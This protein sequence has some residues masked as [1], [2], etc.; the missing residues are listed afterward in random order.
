MP[1]TTNEPNSPAGSSPGDVQE[2]KNS[3]A[4]HWL[5]AVEADQLTA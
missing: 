3:I 5:G 2:A 1:V 4:E